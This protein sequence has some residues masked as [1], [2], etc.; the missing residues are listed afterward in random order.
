MLVTGGVCPTG[1]EEASGNGGKFSLF[2]LRFMWA[3]T[4]PGRLLG[5]SSFWHPKLCLTGLSGIQVGKMTSMMT[6]GGL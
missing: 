2:L 5:M 3:P 4:E 1:G 6:G